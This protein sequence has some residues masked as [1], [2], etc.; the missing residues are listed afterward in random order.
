MI[1]VGLVMNMYMYMWSEMPWS[2]MYISYITHYVNLVNQ[3]QMDFAIVK[4]ELYRDR[5]NWERERRKT[6]Y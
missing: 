6:G 3:H 4:Q 2:G 1:T 5:I